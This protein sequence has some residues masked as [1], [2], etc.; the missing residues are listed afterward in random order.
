MVTFLMSLAAIRFSPLARAFREA[1]CISLCTVSCPDN[2]S[3]LSCNDGDLLLDEEKVIDVHLLQLYQLCVG[4]VRRVMTNQGI[5]ISTDV[6]VR[7]AFE[8]FLHRRTRIRLFNCSLR[9]FR[10]ISVKAFREKANLCVKMVVCASTAD[11]S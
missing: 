3:H 7:V 6:L 4:L 11:C 5:D 10:H 2:E 8:D 9:G 1:F